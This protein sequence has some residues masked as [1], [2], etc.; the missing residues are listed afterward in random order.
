M[1]G[2]RLQALVYSLIIFLLL[3]VTCCLSPVFAADTIGQSLISPASP[4]YFLKSVREVLELKF[5][6]TSRARGLQELEFANRRIREAKSLVKT[7]N[8]NLIE[9][10]LARY[11]AHLQELS[12]LLD[13]GDAPKISALVTQHMLVL[14]TIYDQV[15]LQRA[16]LSIRSTVNRLT[17]WDTEL[18]N[19]LTLIK[20]QKLAQT[21]ID[22]KLSG[23]S[24]L[25]KEASSSALN[26]TEK[27]VLSERAQKCRK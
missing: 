11:I 27:E 15:S 25:S 23:C 10:A 19:K 24:F 6:K 21:V 16:K 4:L 9:P 3:P 14:Q 13:M 17:Q 8:E 2:R 22:S 7:P 12:G 1:K 26:E 20:Q 18:I 5:V